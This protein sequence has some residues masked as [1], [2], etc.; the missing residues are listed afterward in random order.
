MAELDDLLGELKHDKEEGD[1]LNDVVAELEAPLD[2]PA[3]APVS[4]MSASG[5]TRTKPSPLD[6]V[7]AGL[8]GDAPPP[9]QEDAG[10]ATSS[11]DDLLGELAAQ[12]AAKQEEEERALEA[13]RQ[14]RIQE[15][16]NK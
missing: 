6:D 11:I 8:D 7:L 2:V 9:Q 12:K 5:G 3:A 15:A 16:A 1:A 10:P 4:R 13:E 14:R